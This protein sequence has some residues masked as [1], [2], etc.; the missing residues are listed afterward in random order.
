MCSDVRE[1]EVEARGRTTDGLPRE[2]SRFRFPPRT[3]TN[4]PG[5]KITEEGNASSGKQLDL[6]LA[7]IKVEMTGPSQRPRHGTYK[8]WSREQ[9]KMA[10]RAQFIDA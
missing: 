9:F 3:R 6:H 10:L 4:T 7:R 5:F 2:K 8:Q 1:I